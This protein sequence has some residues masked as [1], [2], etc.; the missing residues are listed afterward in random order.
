MK[1]WKTNLHLNHTQGNITCE[2]LKL[3]RGIFEVDPLSLLIFCLDLVG[4][5][6]EFNKTGYNHLYESRIDH[7][8]YKDDLKLCGK[9]NEGFEVSLSPVKIFSDDIGMEFV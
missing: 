6:Y 4:G 3:K 8:L 2:S 7:L 1:E 5:S 9:N